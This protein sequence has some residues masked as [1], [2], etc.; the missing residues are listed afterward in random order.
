MI[1][2]GLVIAPML[3]WAKPIVE[4]LLGPGYGS[5]VQILRVLTVVAFVSAPAALISSAV[6]YLGEGRRRIIVVLGTLLLGS[7]PSTV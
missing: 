4:L 3:V 5:S 6:T 7:V 1:A 2:Q